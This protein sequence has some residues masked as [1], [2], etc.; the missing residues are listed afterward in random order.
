MT[1]DNRQGSSGRPTPAA[2][3]KVDVCA[4]SADGPP[5]TASAASRGGRSQATQGLPGR[6][7]VPPRSDHLSRRITAMRR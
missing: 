3:G 5:H 6:A 2:W 4:G 1:W 7:A